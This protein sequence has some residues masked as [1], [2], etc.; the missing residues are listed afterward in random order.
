MSFGGH[1][2]VIR[3]SFCC[4]SVVILLSF[5]C[6]AFRVGV[7]KHDMAYFAN[8]RTVDAFCLL[9]TKLIFRRLLSATATATGLFA[10]SLR[11]LRF[12]ID[13]ALSELNSVEFFFIGLR[14]ASPYVIAFRGFAPSP[15]GFFAHPFLCYFTFRPHR[16]P[17]CNAKPET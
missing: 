16:L 9:K 10:P 5:G 2:V 17:N 14:F 3:L 7:Q 15:G 8:C 12:N 1:S 13:S 11:P 4:H 6:F